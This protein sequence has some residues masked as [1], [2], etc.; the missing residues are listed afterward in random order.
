MLEILSGNIEKI[1]QTANKVGETISKMNIFNRIE[2]YIEIGNQWLN[3]NFNPTAL[4]IIKIVILSLALISIF[5]LLTKHFKFF[6]IL[7]II[8]GI[9]ITMFQFNPFSKFNTNYDYKVSVK[10]SFNSLVL[11]KDTK[12]KSTKI[13]K[14]NAY[15]FNTKDGSI[16]FNLRNIKNK[17]QVKVY[18]LD[19]ETTPIKPIYIDSEIL[20]LDKIRGDIEIEI[21]AL[22]ELIIDNNTL[23]M[24]HTINGVENDNTSNK[25]EFKNEEKIV[26]KLLPNIEIKNIKNTNI[27]VEKQ[28]NGDL[29]ITFEKDKISGFLAIEKVE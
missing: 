22:K 26:I 16:S 14:E 27:N 19:K 24:I 28:E 6:L 11:T 5:R 17:E 7:S 13:A 18:Y 23:E 2:N 3:T 21:D 25:F 15:K 12:E 4:L 20:V 10:G 8:L 29:I 9:L 1:T